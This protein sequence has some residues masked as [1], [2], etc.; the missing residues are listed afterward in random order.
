MDCDKLQ[1]A[2]QSIRYKQTYVVRYIRTTGTNTSLC[3]V[4]GEKKHCSLRRSRSSDIRPHDQFVVIHGRSFLFLDFGQEWDFHKDLHCSDL[5][6]L[7]PDGLEELQ[8]EWSRFGPNGS[9]VGSVCR[10]SLRLDPTSRL[11][12]SP[13]GLWN[14]ETQAGKKQQGEDR[15]AGLH[16]CIRLVRR[17]TFQGK[18]M[19]S[20]CPGFLALGQ[21]IYILTENDFALSAVSY[22]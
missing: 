19:F 8:V 9:Q 22:L 1:T 10:G 21:N 5:L 2:A 13:L 20:G 11:R 16:A 12:L 15:P 3:L 6:S 14:R 17:G 18:M 7:Q 4:F